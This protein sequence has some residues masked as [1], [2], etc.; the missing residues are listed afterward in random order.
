MPTS[1]GKYGRSQ[2][3]NLDHRRSRWSGRA[4]NDSG[5]GTIGSGIG[6]PYVWTERATGGGWPA[7][8]GS[9][10]IEQAPRIDGGDHARVDVGSEQLVEVDEQVLD[11]TEPGHGQA[12]EGAVV[13]PAREVGG[14]AGD[15]PDAL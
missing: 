13:E 3:P 15:G 14:R 6:P 7:G 4:A 1:E 8:V 5:S 2:A 10:P 12:G 9:G 11:R